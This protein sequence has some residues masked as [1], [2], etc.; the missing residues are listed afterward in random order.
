M[1]SLHHTYGFLR[2]HS[3]FLPEFHA[4]HDFFSLLFLFP[5]DGSPEEISLIPVK[6][7]T[8]E[9]CSDEGGGYPPV[10]EKG[11]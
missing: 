1:N 11:E 9:E 5:S 2:L 3:S 10:N 8:G 7:L 6:A 4:S